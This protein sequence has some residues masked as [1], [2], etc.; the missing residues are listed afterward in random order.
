MKLFNQS[1]KLQNF[2]WRTFIL[3]YYKSPHTELRGITNHT[4]V[5]RD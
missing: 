3:L 4:I 1:T 5:M 2:L